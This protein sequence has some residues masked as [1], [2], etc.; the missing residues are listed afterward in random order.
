VRRT[1]SAGLAIFGAVAT[2]GLLGLS[3]EWLGLSV[4]LPLATIFAVY[5]VLRLNAL[6]ALPPRLA[7]IGRII[8]LAPLCFGHRT[9][10][11]L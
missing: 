8:R 10:G 6:G 2:T 1:F 9:S 3:S 5:A 7:F 4:G 11:E